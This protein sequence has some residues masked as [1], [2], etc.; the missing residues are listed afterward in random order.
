[1]DDCEIFPSVSITLQFLFMM[2]INNLNS[3]K[4]NSKSFYI[5]ID[6][7]GTK[8]ELII[9][10]KFNNEVK[11][12]FDKT[13]K[14]V[15]YSVAGA[16]VY[17]ETVLEFVDDILKVC[18]LRLKDCLGICFGIAGAR[19]DKDRIRLKNIFSKN[20]RVK[21]IRVT[22]DAMTALFGAFKGKDG[23]ILISGTGSVLYGYSDREIIRIGGWGRI[24][25][26]EGSGYWIGKRALNLVTKEFDDSKPKNEKSLLSKKLYEKFGITE[27]NINEKVFN[28]NF[29]IQD[30]APVVLECAGKKCPVSK[31]IVN[32]SA[33]ALTDHIKK[34][35]KLSKRKGNIDIS[36]IGSVI[37]NKNILSDKLK[38]EIQSL[39][40]VT[41]KEKEHSPAFG[42]VLLC[43]ENSTLLSKL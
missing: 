9:A 20:L 24:M 35:L 2:I 14:G 16:E 6:S 25:G 39:K 29:E 36:F 11:V 41:V 19:E 23:I 30:I 21:N 37:E 4:K 10:T 13:Y 5:G 40:N 34:Y 17:C 12:V 42:A 28:G 43:M 26:D 31:Q 27:K 18:S 3:M 1:M 8:C 15:H 38:K 33:E 32:E 7:G 22:T